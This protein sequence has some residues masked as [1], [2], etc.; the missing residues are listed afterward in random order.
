MNV[1]DI[2]NW[3]DR[4]YALDGSIA[5]QL[6]RAYTNDVYLVTTQSLKCVLKLYGIT[7]RTQSEVEYEVA[8]LDHLARKGLRVPRVLVGKDSRK[9]YKTLVSGN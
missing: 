2:T 4:T 9:I 5:C 1:T 6:L 3:L 7:W 8:L